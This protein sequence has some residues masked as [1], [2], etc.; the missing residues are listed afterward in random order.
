METI[1]N[2]PTINIGVIGS[3]SNGKS[4]IVEKI[5]GTKTQ[6]Y[7]TEIKKN[8]TIKLGYA[9]AKIYK[10]SICPEPKCYQSEPSNIF[11][12]NCKYCDNVMILQKHV[13]F[14]DCPGHQT[15]MSTMLNGTCIMD[16]TILVESINNQ[17]LPSQ[18]KEHLS[19][20]K[21]ANLSNSITCINKLDLIKK[22]QAIQKINQIKT[23]LI[24]TMAEHSPIVPIVANYGINI[25]ILCEYICKY[26][27]EPNKDLDSN[28]KMIIVR[29]F[30]INKQHSSIDQL[31]GGVVGGSILKGTLVKNDDIIIY[32][33]VITKGT[34]AKWN[35]KPIVGTV[36]TIHSEKNSLENAIPGGLIGV[37]LDIDPG[38]AAKDGLVGN[39]LTKYPSS[40][41][42]IFETLFIEYELFGNKIEKN[43]I[44]IINYNACNEK[45]Q[46]VKMKGQKAELLLLDRPICV[47]LGDFITL[48]HYSDSITT[49]LGRGKII[50]GLESTEN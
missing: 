30:N 20:T 38:L 33:G 32:P 45:S 50:D 46:V 25:D 28:V 34:T 14:V 19:A 13:S 23:S 49:V 2:Q 18:T 11:T 16:T 31:E 42:K 41:L 43:D 48:S 1:H 3:V 24:G 8:I 35:Y 6:K 26:C 47:S 27:P 21:M 5:T 29:S 4:S 36:L 7:S 9:N 44:L 37:K 22:D 40:D 39:I 12:S 10:C 15:L 17:T